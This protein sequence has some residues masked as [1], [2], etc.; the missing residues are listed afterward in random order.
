VALIVAIT[1][2]EPGSLFRKHSLVVWKRFSVLVGFSIKGAQSVHDIVP[3]DSSAESIHSEFRRCFHRA[4]IGGPRRQDGTLFGEGEVS[5][6]ND[7]HRMRESLSGMQQRI[8]IKHVLSFF[9][10]RFL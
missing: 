2:R 7:I 9:G 10:F 8:K 6:A 3:T 5:V 4:S 1:T